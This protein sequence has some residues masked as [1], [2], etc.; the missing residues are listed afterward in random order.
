M[1]DLAVEY[2]PGFTGES[3]LDTVTLGDTIDYSVL[4]EICKQAMQQPTELLENVALSIST[5]IRA[6][7]KKVV[8]ME[9]R[10]TK[11]KPPIPGCTGS[12]SVLFT[13]KA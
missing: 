4:F 2:Y 11:C 10:I 5:S 6:Q 7:F 1:V 8:R 12:S 3:S 13:W 9:I